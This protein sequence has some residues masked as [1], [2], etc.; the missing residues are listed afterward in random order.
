[1]EIPDDAFE[2]LLEQMRQVQITLRNLR[3]DF[4]KWRS[5][6]VEPASPAPME[7]V[8]PPT[9]KQVQFLRGLG[10]NDIPGSKED[11]R[12]LLQ[13]LSAKREAGEYSVPPTERQLK[14]LRDLNYAG[15]IP[16]SKE[17]AWKLLQ[18]LK[19]IE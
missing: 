11:A 3:S 12:R 8:D 7:V 10:V 1:M 17:A 9:E 6:T 14:Y 15:P 2:A 5:S 18:Q 4:G 13:E 16:A 19:A